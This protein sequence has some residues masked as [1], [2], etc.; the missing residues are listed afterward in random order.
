MKPHLPR[1]DTFLTHL[2]I[3]QFSP[4][5]LEKRGSENTISSCIAGWWAKSICFTNM[6]AVHLDMGE[7]VIKFRVSKLHVVNIIQK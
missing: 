2:F 5:P 1:A 7:V 3:S 6:L 4:F